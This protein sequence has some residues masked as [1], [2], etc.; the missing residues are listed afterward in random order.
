MDRIKHRKA[1][2]DELKSLRKKNQLFNYFVAR[3]RT[4]KDELRSE[5]KLLNETIKKREDRIE[6]LGNEIY[7]L[8]SNFIRVDRDYKDKIIHCCNYISELENKV[9]DLE[10]Q[11]GKTKQELIEDFEYEKKGIAGV[12]SNLIDRKC[13][14]RILRRAM[15]II[16]EVINCE[17][18]TR[19][20]A[21]QAAYILLNDAY[22]YEIP[23]DT[24]ITKA[25]SDVFAKIIGIARKFGL[26]FS[27]D[28]M[29]KKMLVLKYEPACN[30]HPIKDILNTLNES[31]KEKYSFRIPV[32]KRKQAFDEPVKGEED[33][34]ISVNELADR[35]CPE[36]RKKVV[37]NERGTLSFK[38]LWERNY[39]S[40]KY[41]EKFKRE[42]RGS[43][44]YYYG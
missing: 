41:E 25:I 2:A 24:N 44:E 42:Y 10:N 36:V 21:A 30:K 14:R 39:P 43:Y 17:Y 1:E 12:I 5:V 27:W 33:K 29:Q 8:K 7:Y 35:H 40:N 4:E 34:P 13:K 15:R 18:T 32:I 23:A 19:I 31:L 20:T 6:G 37:V 9:D 26:G 38:D 28:K 22:S 11:I 16:N 3:E